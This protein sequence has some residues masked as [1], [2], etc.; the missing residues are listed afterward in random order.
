[1]RTKYWADLVVAIFLIPAPVTLSFVVP[2]SR[3]N[4]QIES[5]LYGITMVLSAI[6]IWAGA[7]LRWG[8]RSG[9]I[10]GAFLISL[11][12]FVAF[13]LAQL[14]G[15]WMQFFPIAFYFI[16]LLIYLVY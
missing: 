3:S 12:F 9:A 14:T 7:S 1:M 5:I 16:A 8:N 2:M 11:E 10:A 15:R 4:H 6:H 13:V